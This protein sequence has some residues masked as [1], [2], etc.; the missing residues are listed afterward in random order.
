MQTSGRLRQVVPPEVEAG[1]VIR[2]AANFRNNVLRNALTTVSLAAIRTGRYG[3]AEAAARERSSLPPNPYS[4]LD[5]QDE[6]SRAQVTLAHAIV[7][8]GRAD[9]ARQI[10]EPEIARYREQVKRGASGL[11]FTQD[12]AY[13]LYVDALARPPGD[14]RRAAVRERRLT[15]GAAT[16]CPRSAS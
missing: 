13:A 14:A 15:A 9:E 11:S 5:P 10:A 6:V 1:S 4:E 16:T 8:Q 7:L 2:D 3:E 12:F